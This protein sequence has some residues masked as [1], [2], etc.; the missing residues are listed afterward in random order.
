MLKITSA[1]ESK[2]SGQQ[3][4]SYFIDSKSRMYFILFYLLASFSYFEKMK[5]GLCDNH[6]VSMY[7]PLLIYECLN[8]SLWNLVC[9]SWHPSPSQRH[10][11]W[12]LC[13]SLC[14]FVCVSSIVARQRPGISF[15][16]ATN[17]RN[18]RRIVGRI[19]FIAVHVVSRKVDD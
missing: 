11:S 14:V 7:S 5:I 10:I 17:T 15:T 6:A 8:Q 2:V 1:W 9:I 19:V 18:N 12:I 13:I 16:S 3:R 4:N